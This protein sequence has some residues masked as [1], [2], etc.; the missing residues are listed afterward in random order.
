MV[1]LFSVYYP[2]RTVIL[3]GAEA[4]LVCTSFLLGCL[5]R[6]GQD[7][8]LVL[9]YE[10]G[11]AKILGITG[12]ALLCLY[13]NDLYDLQ[14]LRIPA[15]TY[16]RLLMVLG[17]FSLALAALSYFFPGLVV[18]R[19]VYVTGL[20]ILTFVLLGWRWTFGWLLRLPVFQEK[21]CVLGAGP[22][23]SR[24]VEIEGPRCR[25]S[26]SR[27]RRCR[28]GYEP[29]GQC[30]TNPGVESEFGRRPPHESGQT[31]AHVRRSCRGW[32][33]VS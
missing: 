21:V 22:R 20:A 26:P 1:R 5:V 8:Y 10:H 33:P 31:A 32:G 12:L 11:F 7:T 29:A 9:N 19:G 30:R 28:S 3:V 4:I 17:I 2:T 18:G 13:Y 14:R 16:V 27:H 24:L 15:E 6:F 23:A 25:F